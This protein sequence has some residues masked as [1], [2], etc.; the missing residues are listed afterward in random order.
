MFCFDALF[1][2]DF[3]IFDFGRNFGNNCYN[4]KIF[5]YFY[6]YKNDLIQSLQYIAVYDPDRILICLDQLFLLHLHQLP[7]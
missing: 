1:F 6:K 7:G 3:S 5:M 2:C 4:L